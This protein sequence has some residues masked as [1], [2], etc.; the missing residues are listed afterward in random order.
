MEQDK[1]KEK[2]QKQPLKVCLA[3][4]CFLQLLILIN[5]L[6]ACFFNVKLYTSNSHL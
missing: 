1:R 6:L 2:Q 4:K 5:I 3:K